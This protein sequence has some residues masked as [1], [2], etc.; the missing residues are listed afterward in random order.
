MLTDMLG[1]IVQKLAR[2]PE[3]K[4]GPLFDLLEKLLGRDG[5]QWFVAFKL[6]LRKEIPRPKILKYITTVPVSG[7]KTFVVADHFRVGINTGVRIISLGDNFRSHFLGK[8]ESGVASAKLK[9]YKFTE[10]SPDAPIIAELD[11]H[12]E[13]ALAHLWGLLKK[14]PNGETGPLLINGS[15]NIFYICD[16][17]SILWAVVAS[18]GGSGWRV[19]ADLVKDPDRWFAS[20]QV[21][22]R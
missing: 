16:A 14:Q 4:L 5:D 20:H 22:S 18:W 21:I 15:A 17:E 3:E 9:V 10:S 2:L 8:T 7:A 1:R 6:F 11:G 13:V 12:H 19:D